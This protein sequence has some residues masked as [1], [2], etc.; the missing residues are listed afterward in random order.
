[1]DTIHVT[2]ADE[3]EHWLVVT[4]VT[5]IKASAQDTSGK[6]LVLEVTVLPGG[7]PPVLHRHEYSE[8]FLFQEGEF[9][10]STVNEDFELTAY[11]V[12]AGDTVSVPSMAWHN[13]RNVGTTPGRFI[14]VHSPPVMEGFM[15]EIGR[16]MDD[17]NNPPEPGAPPSEEE[18]RRMMEIIGK[19]MEVLP[20]ENVRA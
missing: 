9:E 5:T 6:L 14:A 10:V 7:G 16:Q 12:G 8:V 4:D 20:P 13:F 15:R 11:K 3:G 2:R 1:M 18:M 19:Y 17:P